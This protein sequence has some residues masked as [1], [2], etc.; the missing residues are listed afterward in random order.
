MARKL[1]PPHLSF[2]QTSKLLINWGLPFF[3]RF[4]CPPFLGGPYY[5]FRGREI[6]AKLH[7]LAKLALFSGDRRAQRRREPRMARK[8]D[9]SETAGDNP[10]RRR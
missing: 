10:W 6:L 3:F 5:G 9:L 8:L 7:H 1:D 2:S 4:R